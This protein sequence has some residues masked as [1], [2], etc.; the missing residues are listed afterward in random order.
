MGFGGLGI[1]T[2]GLRAA[3]VNLA[4]TG[5]NMANAE[6]AGFSRQRI[7]QST[8]FTRQAGISQSHH[9][10]IIGMGTDWQAVHQ[11]RNEFL[12]FHYR[13]NVSRLQ[14]Y[15]TIVQAGMVVEGAL[16]ELYGAYNFQSVVNNLW[17]SIQ[18]LTI[19]PAGLET[20]QLLLANINSFLNK[21]QSV[22]TTLFEYQ[23]NLDLQI[24]E[25]VNGPNGINATVSQI[26]HL[27]LQI[28]TI[29]VAGDNANDFRDERN[30]ALDRL[31]QM[32]PI[33]VRI[34]QLGDVNITSLGHNILTQGHQNMMG[35][36]FVSDQFNFVEPVFTH[37]P[38]I[39]SSGTSPEEFQS[40]M[41]YGRGVSDLQGNDFGEL[42]ALML[43]RGNSPAHAGSAETPRPDRADPRS[44]LPDNRRRRPL[45]PRRCS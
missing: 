39:L 7:V 38:G 21:A 29:E 22:Y 31:A 33:D 3:Q 24:R 2:S 41:N 8:G 4:V 20:R 28:R 11:I 18:E 16:G 12:D 15:S 1:A 36:R 30:R 44:R 40:F 37:Q 19:N 35:L 45:L 17:Y 10:H 34:C 43:A 42:K 6:I 27:N 5:H 14:F 9:P 23:Q 32:I 26:N 25:M 13:Q